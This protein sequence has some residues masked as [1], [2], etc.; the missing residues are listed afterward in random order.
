MIYGL[1][2]RSQIL[3]LGKPSGFC[4]CWTR[5]GRAFDAWKG[6]L[7]Q[8]RANITATWR[9]DPWQKRHCVTDD[10]LEGSFHADPNTHAPS[11]TGHEQNPVVRRRD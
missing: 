7:E 4:V 8:R 5:S 2:Q 10:G 11:E 6:G 9:A 3:V 1:H